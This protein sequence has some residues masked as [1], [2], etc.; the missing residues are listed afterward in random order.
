M[1]TEAMS[2]ND[3]ENRQSFNMGVPAAGSS[4]DP[5]FGFLHTVQQFPKHDTV[6]LSDLP[7]QNFFDNSG[8]LVSN[9]E[10]L[11]HSSANTSSE[12]SLILAGL[13]IEYESIRV[14]A[15]AMGVSFDLLAEMLFDC[16]NLALDNRIE[17]LSQLLGGVV[18]FL[19]VE[20]EVEGFLTIDLS[21]NC[22]VKLG[23]QFKSAIIA[24]MNP[25]KEFLINPC[26]C[27]VIS[28]K[29]GR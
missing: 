27:I 17:R 8:V 13:P 28:F 21:V 15:S 24:L 12:V 14:V 9:P 26:R 25:L 11:C 22:V 2:G 5:S 18:I 16:E 20:V 29:G 4:P 10:F 3:V 1:V 7:P 6:K 19:V 23:I